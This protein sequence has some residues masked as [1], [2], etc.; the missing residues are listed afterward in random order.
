M[1]IVPTMMMSIMI[2][3]TVMIMA[4]IYAVRLVGCFALALTFLPAAFWVS[5]TNPPRNL[6]RQ[7]LPLLAS[8]VIARGA[9]DRGDGT[10][11][12]SLGVELGS[13]FRCA[14]VPEAN[15][16][17]GHRLSLLIRQSL[18]SSGLR[19]KSATEIDSLA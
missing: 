18:I 19:R 9:V 3:T 16:V 2:I 13:I 11:W 7:H 1:T 10:V 14:V 8:R 5:L 12:E 17:F 15:H 4:M 6:D